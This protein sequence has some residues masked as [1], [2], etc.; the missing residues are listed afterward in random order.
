MKLFLIV[1]FAVCLSVCCVYAD[2]YIDFEVLKISSR[3]GRIVIKDP[4]GVKSL[5]KTG[6]KLPGKLTVDEITE[7]YVVFIK[8]AGDDLCRII[9]RLGKNGQI[10]ERISSLPEPDKLLYKPLKILS[11]PLKITGN[12]MSSPELVQDK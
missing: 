8:R 3:D 4:K 12:N 10:V 6:D 2:A 5:I 7:N 9:V 1:L 11:K